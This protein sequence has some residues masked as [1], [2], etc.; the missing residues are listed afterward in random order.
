MHVRELRG[1]WK[2]EIENKPSIHSE[3]WKAFRGS[4]S[5]VYYI[6]LVA[7]EVAVI[8][9]KDVLSLLVPF[10]RM[11]CVPASSVYEKVYNQSCVCVCNL[12]LHSFPSEISPEHCRTLQPC[13]SDLRCSEIQDTGDEVNARRWLVDSLTWGISNSKVEP[14]RKRPLWRY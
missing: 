5:K 6:V 2:F 12:F 7:N 11:L 8:S 13:V 10:F 14:R 9:L 1:C 3:S 4:V